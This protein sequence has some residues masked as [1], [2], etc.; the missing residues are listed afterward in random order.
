MNQPV[1]AWRR[2][3][4]FRLRSLLL[5]VLVAAIAFALYG[6]SRK[7]PPLGLDGYCPVTL[8]HKYKWQLGD[9][10]N[11]A[12]YEGRLY[13]FVG[14][15]ERALF[16]SYPD[17]YAP[18]RSGVDIVRL[19]DENREVQGERAH[20]LTYNGRIY[21]FDSKST[22]DKFEAAPGRYTKLSTPTS[23]R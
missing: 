20:G 8:I 3:L 21:L 12:V 5:F 22:L 17:R 16:Q 13:L 10:Q 9:P 14:Q 23:S 15:K 11:D 2:V 1:P 18:I 4:T 7:P 19:V 6:R